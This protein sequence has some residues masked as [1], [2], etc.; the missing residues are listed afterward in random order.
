MTLSHGFR[1]VRTEELPEINTVG[2]FYVHEKTGAEVLSL[3]NDDEN[4][5]FGISFRTPVSNSTGV[6]H[7]LEHS[8]LCGSRKYPLKEPFVDL[9]RGSLQTFL[10]AFTYP[11]RTCYPVASQNLQDF[12]NLMDVYLD[13]VFYPRLQR[14]IF[15]Q[16]GWH[17]EIDPQ[18]GKLVYRGVVFNEMKGA[19]A[20]PD[21]NLDNL[22]RE[23]LFPANGYRHDSGGNPAVIPDLTY[24]AFVEFHRTHYHPSNSM[25][26][27]YGDDPEEARLERLNDYFKDFDRID[28]PPLVALQPALPSPVR[29]TGA[30]PAGQETESL[31]QTSVNWLL[32]Q[33]SEIDANYS[34]NLLEEVLLGTPVSPL[35]KALLDSG[36]GEDL[37][38]SGLSTVMRQMT[39]S[40]GMKGVTPA[41][42]ESVERLI[43]AT[44]E[45]IVDEGVPES[46][47]EAAFNTLEFQMR[48]NNTGSF[49]RG[50]A[51]M[52]RS[53]TTW[54][55]DG[56]PL[57]PVAFQKPMDRLREQVFGVGDVNKHLKAL[58]QEHLLQN[59]HRITATILPDTG[60]D[61]AW[62][63]AEEKR[64]ERIKASLGANELSIISAEFEQLQR[65]QH[66]PDS[67]EAQASLPTLHLS[68]LPR[69][70]KVTPT[71]L[72][73]HGD[74]Q[75]LSHD[76][77]SNGIL[78]AQLAFNLRGLP[79]RLVPY[80][81][82]FSRSLTELG[83]M[84]RDATEFTRW[85]GCKTGGV[86]ASS[87][88]TTVK[89]SPLPAARLIVTGKAT[90]AHI[91]DLFA[92]IREAIL[93]VNLDN[94]Q[95]FE[96]MV[97]EEKA[98]LEAALAPAGR[99][100]IASRLQS[101]YN[102]EGWF[103]E[104]TGGIEYLMFVR[105]LA[106]RI[107]TEWPSILNDLQSMLALL[108]RRNNLVI[109]LTADGKTLEAAHGELPRLL[110]SLNDAPIVDAT[111]PMAMDWQNAGFTI[112]GQVNHVGLAVDLAKGGISPTG[113]AIAIQK[114]LGTTWLWER[115][116]Q[117]GGAY[118]AGASISR[119]TGIMAFT[120]YRDPN[121][122]RTLDN[123]RNAA[124]YLES[125]EI[126]DE[127]LERTV[128]GSIGTMDAYQLPDGRGFTALVHHLAGITDDWRQQS[129]EELLATTRDDIRAF[130]AAL[131][132]V[133]PNARFG[134]VASEAA[135]NAA[136]AEQPGLLQTVR[137][138]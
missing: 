112:P 70:V 109:N 87:M 5:C 103:S 30:Y 38:P 79:A 73:S 93:E 137:V 6:A 45:K 13:T 117:E 105:K 69:E 33:S 27:V 31:A 67:P 107:S 119:L 123:F 48:E 127:E 131:Q 100:F 47:V 89:D 8:V 122:T 50:L 22:V 41:N 32:P 138:M 101:S 16:E 96:Q 97:Q 29:V 68:D 126:S 77:F 34:L 108:I 133:L 85:I 12:Y 120:S 28:R 75:V 135:I 37:T 130:G 9:L 58:I 62:T 20:S 81:H 24:E 71:A 91:P 124:R 3:V 116:R 104:T 129:R 76:L 49:P 42:T 55:Y 18:G 125:L 59:Q 128:V 10:N 136:N 115:V 23:S 15:Q 66:T 44:L 51:L 114:L 82:L 11:D 61:K 63:E 35:R 39:F 99:S 106:S 2:H 118:G 64:L 52:V 7:I 72:T 113:T 21:D 26:V 17:I 80:L 57:G 84:T 90:A 83:T 53:L 132:S 43:I 134:A 56:D 19:Y 65:M 40:V 1:L 25:T 86:G 94:R 78:Y 98:R 88:A 110:Q 14:E 54:T 46:A 36:L 95:R 74:V 102:Q 111:W 4:K 121:L 60:L 92:I